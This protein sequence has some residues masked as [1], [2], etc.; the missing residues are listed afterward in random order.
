MRGD[1]GDQTSAASDQQEPR[2]EV[3]VA[4][5]QLRLA[6][7]EDKTSDDWPGKRCAGCGVLFTPITYRPGYGFYVRKSR[8]TC[9]AADCIRRARNKKGATRRGFSA[10]TTCRL[11]GILF[12]PVRYASSTRAFHMRKREACPVCCEGWS[13]PRAAISAALIGKPK[14]SVLGH[15]HWNWRGG[16]AEHVGR[17]RGW[18]ALKRRI[19]KSQNYLCGD[20]GKSQTELGYTLH[21]HHKVPYQSFLTAKE[22]NRVTNLVALCRI[23]HKAAEVAIEVYQMRLDLFGTRPGVLRG[24]RQPNSKLTEAAVLQI[25]LLRSGG[26]SAKA[27]AQQFGVD[28]STISNICAGDTWRHVGGPLTFNRRHRPVLTKSDVVPMPQTEFAPE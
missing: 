14:D 2:R 16:A 24:S 19:R 27:I 15:K 7:S 4:K 20:C 11:C 8:E 18:K 1:W 23:C 21:V 22:A 12:T 5:D 13:G 26:T 10:G 3:Q 28:P 6:E 9:G 25:R 17:G